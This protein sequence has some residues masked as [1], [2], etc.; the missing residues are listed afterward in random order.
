MEG[1]REAGPSVANGSSIMLLAE[2]KAHGVLLT[3]DGHAPD[4]VASIKR[5]LG[6]RQAPAS[7]SNR[8]SAQPQEQQRLVLSA[9]KPSHHG[10]ARNLTEAVMD[11]ID[12][13]R[14][15]I[16]TDGSVH[17]H[18]DQ[19]ALLRILRYS[20]RKP[21]FFFNYD[22]ETTRKWRDSNEDVT[23]AGF[24]DYH[25]QY[26]SAVGNGLMLNFE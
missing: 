26:P 17:R 8:V 25:T 9:F 2:Y 21:C 5:L 4:L 15:L 11:H 22:V 10:S 1:W 20:L 6:N 23:E 12:C 14:Y 3:G 18:P 19:Q 24:R 7:G 13:S 16:S